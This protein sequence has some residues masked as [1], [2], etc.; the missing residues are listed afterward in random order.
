MAAQTQEAHHFGSSYIPASEFESVLETDTKDS[1]LVERF[2]DGDLEA[3]DLL[4]LRYRSRIHGVIRSFISNPEDA[5]DVTQDVFL[6]AYQG[7]ANFKKAS[8]FYSWLYRITINRCIDYMRQ[9]SKHRVISDDPVSD[10]VF[11]GNVANRHPSAPSKAVENEEFYVHLR[12]A[13]MQLS[14]KQ[15]EVFILRYREELPLKEIGRKMGRSTGTIKAHL[16][17]AQRNLRV[18]LLPYLRDE[19]VQTQ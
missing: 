1:Q 4:Y 16:F 12:R 9:R 11:Y 18:L 10:D 15:R 3:F 7:L 6:K 13:V 14:P 2:Q 19:R 8:Q 17:Q 5:L